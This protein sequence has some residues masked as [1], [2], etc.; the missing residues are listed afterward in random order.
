MR[1]SRIVPSSRDTDRKETPLPLFEFKTTSPANGPRRFFNVD[2]PTLADPLRKL[3]VQEVK[4]YRSVAA[5]GYING[6]DTNTLSEIGYQI[7]EAPAVKDFLE[8]HSAERQY[9]INSALGKAQEFGDVLLGVTALEAKQTYKM[10]NG[11]HLRL[12]E[13]LFSL[14]K[15]VKNLKPKE[16]YQIISDSWLEYR[17]GIKP[18]I[19][20]MENL[21]KWF[22]SSKMYD[23][24][25][26]YGAVIAEH[27]NPK[28]WFGKLPLMINGQ[29]SLRDVEVH[30]N[31]NYHKAGFNYINSLDSR[32]NSHLALLGLD[33]KSIASTIYEAIPFSFI[34]DMFVNMGNAI[35]SEN[36]QHEFQTYN[37]YTSDTYDLTIKISGDDVTGPNAPSYVKRTTRKSGYYASETRNRVADDVLCHIFGTNSSPSRGFEYFEGGKIIYPTNVFDG[38][39][40]FDRYGNPISAVKGIYSF[41]G[42][43]LLDPDRYEFADHT[44]HEFQHVELE[45]GTFASVSGSAAMYYEDLEYEFEWNGRTYNETHRVTL[46]C[47]SEHIGLFGDPYSMAN[48]FSRFRQVVCTPNSGGYLEGA[49]TTFC[50]TYDRLVDENGEFYFWDV[51]GSRYQFFKKTAYRQWSLQYK[52][53][54]SFDDTLTYNSFASSQK[55]LPHARLVTHSVYL[56]LYSLDLPVDQYFPAILFERK[57]LEEIHFELLSDPELSNEQ[58]IDLAVFSERIISYF[59]QFRKK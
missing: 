31:K 48:E 26:S 3:K 2:C 50:R 10:L 54:L 24:Q 46:P 57:K 6:R 42:S 49:G 34:L 11:L 56:E 51:T 55:N 58:V 41:N 23:V 37:G 14:Y 17:Y 32:N 13:T 22:N 33:I 45:D 53:I 40:N 36:F 52:P 20:D 8:S 39:P 59:A 35:A 25:S 29:P 21:Y 18:F 47:P 28:L 43:L 1:T 27:D 7:C 44:A 16:A 5:N 19:G 30:L 12:A 4:P 9:A 38:I 15:A